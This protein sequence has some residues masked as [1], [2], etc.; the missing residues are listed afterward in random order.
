MAKASTHLY[1]S[2]TSF[3]TFSLATASFLDPN[4]AAVSK[5]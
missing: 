2:F 5:Q 4:L 3:A 1:A